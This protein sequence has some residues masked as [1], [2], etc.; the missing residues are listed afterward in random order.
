MIPDFSNKKNAQSRASDAPQKTST[1]SRDCRTFP[2]LLPHLE[3]DSKSFSESFSAAKISQPLLDSCKALLSKETHGISYRQV[4]G[5]LS[6]APLILADSELDSKY[7]TRKLIELNTTLLEEYNQKKASEGT[8]DL[9]LASIPLLGRPRASTKFL[10]SVAEVNSIIQE[11]ER[12]GLITIE[13]L[14]TG[15]IFTGDRLNP[16]NV[17]ERF[18]RVDVSDLGALLL[19]V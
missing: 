5:M 7:L 2:Q 15:N 1:D 3:S 14:S 10:E 17:G 16:A 19:S 4:L 13:Y 12:V 9:V 18:M 6:R 11:M 8:F